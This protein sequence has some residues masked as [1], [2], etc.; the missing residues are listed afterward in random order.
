MTNVF[1][2]CLWTPD[3]PFAKTGHVSEELQ[4]PYEVRLPFPKAMPV[5][6]Q[7]ALLGPLSINSLMLVSVCLLGMSVGPQMSPRALLWHH[8]P[9]SSLPQ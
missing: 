7:S 5:L 4:V 9:P 1:W 8:Q 6:P 3:L 2:E